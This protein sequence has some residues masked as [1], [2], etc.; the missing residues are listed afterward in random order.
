ML[1]IVAGLTAAAAADVNITAGT[2][3]Y[4]PA[5]MAGKNLIVSGADTTL[6]ISS[7]A[8]ITTM[9]DLHDGARVE[10]SGTITRTGTGNRGIVGGNGN[11]INQA[12]GRITSA[13]GSGVLFYEGGTVLNTGAGSLIDAAI[14]GVVIQGTTGTVTN[15]LGASIGGD[16]VGV[17]LFAGGDVT[18]SGGG[19]SITG[20]VSIL[21]G[22]GNLINK[23]GAT[24]NGPGAAIHLR[25]GGSISNTGSGSTLS[26]DVSGA[27]LENGGTLSNGAG[28][29]ITGGDDGVK[30]DDVIELD[31]AGSIVGET[32][33]G[34]DAR[35]GS[36]TNSGAAAKIS[37]ADT[38]V[39]LDGVG[40]VTNE[41]GAKISGGATGV[42]MNY[43][44]DVTNTGG[45][46]ITGDSGGVVVWECGTVTN[47][48]T[49][50]LIAGNVGVDFTP[51]DLTGPFALIN[52]GGAEIE[53]N[54]AAVRFYADGTVTNSTGAKLTGD[55]NGLVFDDGAVGTVTNQSGGQIFGGYAG[56]N[57]SGTGTLTNSG[58]GSTVSA[59]SYA[60]FFEYDEGDTTNEDGAAIVSINGSGVVYYAGGTVNNTSAASIDAKVSGVHAIGGDSSVTN[61]GAGSSIHGD[62]T[63]VFIADGAGTVVNADGARISGGDSGIWLRDGGSV[64]NGAGSTISGGFAGIFTYGDAIVDNAGT[65]EGNVWMDIGAYNQVTLH[66]GSRINGELALE[67][68]S[69]SKLTLTGAGT[70][71]Y[72]AAVTGN[73]KFHGTLIKSG[74]GT[75]V[76]DKD[77]YAQYTSVGAGTLIVGANG[78][79]RL[80]SDV[81]VTATGTIGGSGT[82]LGNLIVDG[83]VRPGNSIGTLTVAGYQQNAGSIYTV[84]VDPA[85]SASDR[86]EATG[87]ANLIDGAVL[88]V[89]RTNA[90]PYVAGTRYTVLSSAIGLSGTFELTGDLS[91]SA[92]LTLRD[93][94][95]ANNAYLLV[96]QTRQLGAAASTASQQA[97]ADGLQS[98]GPGN[99]AFNA[100]AN[101]PDDTAAAEAFDQLD[102]DIHAALPSALLG[103]A[104]L[105]REAAIDRLR[106]GLCALRP[107]LQATLQR[108]CPEATAAPAFWSTGYGGWSH[109]DGLDNRSGGLLFGIDA[110][111]SG[112]W[113]AGLYAGTGHSRIESGGQRATTSDYTIGAYAGGTAGNVALRVGASTSRHDISTTR[114][115]YIPGLS[116]TL[117]G[118]YGATGFEAFGEIGYRARFAGAE[119][120]PFARV[121][122]SGMASDGFS[123]QG[124]DAAL[125][126]RA[127]LASAT[128]TLG[129]HTS[130]AFML[131]DLPAE[132]GGALGWSHTL[133]DPAA[134][135]ELAFAGS[136]SFRI[137]DTPATDAA[138]L[139]IDLTIALAPRASLSLGYDGA[140]ATDATRQSLRGRLAVQF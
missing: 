17:M 127:S 56:V 41:D 8:T 121:A 66:T 139:A 126:G 26:G 102:G 15:E 64:T 12:G 80:D 27:Y 60:V 53:G 65:V 34:I 55:I 21:G 54:Y 81:D 137:T 130:M 108:P 47:S 9:V 76:I 69:S 22:G 39:F 7:G 140:L 73:T 10:N 84:E 83:R 131:G 86:I 11:A 5:A 46:S 107:E 123:E 2:V 68:N 91:P 58:L 116:T 82:I 94:Y 138:L 67:N 31:N 103:N 1:A 33:N 74:S 70:Q 43:G 92:F 13:N 122:I 128:A 97:V 4:D 24:I 87:V 14:Y 59:N 88:E 6:V 63:G 57:F 133:G 75:W 136:D 30:A 111:V 113:R 99:A 44:G 71:L 120:E 89:V 49:G 132:V 37:G 135:A 104:A 36:V 110:D 114:G 134:V 78:S 3:T 35:G 23:D 61:T 95:D 18:N 25:G 51:Y 96:E 38:G 101:L 100:V 72:S 40:T 118:D 124:G 48:G 85:S 29:L 129:I 42:I 28:A 117:A 125:S 109:R 90:A 115:V 50:S 112:D 19:S 16:S 52:E 79:G 32:R 106:A 20:G 119:V 45:S 93:A 77:L 98:A 105:L 62:D